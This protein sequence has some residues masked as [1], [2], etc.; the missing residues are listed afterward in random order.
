MHPVLTTT[1]HLVTCSEGKTEVLGRLKPLNQDQ[2]CKGHS[3]L[4]GLDWFTGC[5]HL[6]PG[7]FEEQLQILDAQFAT[8]EA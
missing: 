5:Q 3:S 1:P 7:F 6:R 2:L 4:C 8:S